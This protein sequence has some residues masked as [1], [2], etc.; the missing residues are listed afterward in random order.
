M[1]VLGALLLMLAALFFKDRTVDRLD[2]VNAEVKSS[3]MEI[4][5]IIALKK[6][7][8]DKKLGSRVKEI[9]NG[10]PD[11]KIKT[12]ALKGR[13][14]QAIFHNLNENEVNRIIQ[15]LENTAVQ[16]VRLNVKREGESYRME[17]A[18]KW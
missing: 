15:K 2:S 3:L 18:C 11:T 16:I 17:I 1:I 5:E 12:F 10:I 4:G 9:R 6:Q 14:L 7:W 13:K 8:G